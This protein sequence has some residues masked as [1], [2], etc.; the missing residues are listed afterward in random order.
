MSKRFLKFLC[1]G[2]VCTALDF[3]LFYILYYLL[4]L[5]I[6]PANILSYGSGL[7]LSFF[8][9]RH[10]TFKDSAQK[11]VNRLKYVLL[12]GYI[13]LMLNTAI[14]WGIALI[15]PAFIGKVIAVI[16]VVFYN[17]YTNKKL[18]FQIEK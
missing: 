1:V 10:L 15:L 2:G 3:V 17:Y 18:V 6:V 8:I 9:N 14:V 12:Y 4:S 7:T 16:I 5:H 11:Q 13:G